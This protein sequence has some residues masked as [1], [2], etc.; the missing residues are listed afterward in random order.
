[1]CELNCLRLINR[2]ESV[3]KLAFAA[4]FRSVCV[5]VVFFKGDLYFKNFAVVGAPF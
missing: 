5:C 4:K 3:L 1:M 2:N